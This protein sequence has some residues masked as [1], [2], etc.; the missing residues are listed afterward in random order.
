M[1]PT[2]HVTIQTL[3]LAKKEKKRTK[4]KEIFTFLFL[5]FA[6]LLSDLISCKNLGL[7]SLKLSLP[8]ISKWNPTIQ[9]KDWGFLGPI[10]SFLY[11]FCS[12]LLEVFPYWRSAEVLWGEIC[13]R[14]IGFL[15][16]PARSCASYQY[17]LLQL[18]YS[19]FIQAAKIYLRATM[20]E[21]LF[22]MFV[23]EN[24]VRHSIYLKE[25]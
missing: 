25:S 14:E 13:G 18:F 3:C 4:K 5:T 17:V 20:Y 19:L 21:A 2:S 9:D 7:T 11:F 16:P 8:D 12:L 24:W 10:S 1:P 22:Y 15:M 23:G 6:Y